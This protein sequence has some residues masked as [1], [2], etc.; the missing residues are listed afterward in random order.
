[1]SKLRAEQTLQIQK[2]VNVVYEGIADPEQMSRYFIARS[3]GR[4]EKG[5]TVHW[6][7]P[8]FPD[9]FPVTGKRMVVDEYISFDWSGGEPG[10]LVE[11]FLTPMPDGSTLVKV[12]EGER[13][14][15]FSGWPAR[16]AAG[17]TSWL[18]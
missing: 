8:E 15:T 4:L 3:S 9:V 11:I 1:M 10:M 6:E 2:P 14:M 12:V 17:P 18:V 7:F 5:A 13:I 16:L